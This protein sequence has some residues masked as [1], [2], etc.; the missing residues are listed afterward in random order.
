M[1]IETLEKYEV[2]IGC[3][4]IE[5]EEFRDWLISQGHE[6][7]I[8]RSTGSYIDGVWTDKYPEANDI[9]NSLW[10]AYCNS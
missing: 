4:G 8:G 2:E 5:N 10:S 3:D 6:A 9:L 1:K 7:K